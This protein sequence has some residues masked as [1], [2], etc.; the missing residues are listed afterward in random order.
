MNIYGYLCTESLHS[1]VH[2]L[3]HSVQFTVGCKQLSTQYDAHSSIH[4]TTHTVQ[5]IV[6]HSTMPTYVFACVRVCVCDG[7]RERERGYIY[8]YI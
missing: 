6:V 3:T 1:S 8:I 2:C 5:Y 4:C 7:N